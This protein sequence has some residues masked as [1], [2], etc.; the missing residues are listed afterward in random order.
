MQK[1]QCIDEMK[2]DNAK[3]ILLYLYLLKK[4]T[5]K[6]FKFLFNHLIN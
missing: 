4:E 5:N 1:F 3:R 2:N 6:K